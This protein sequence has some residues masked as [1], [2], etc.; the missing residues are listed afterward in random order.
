MN[1]WCS[2]YF[3]RVV[4]FETEVKRGASQ[5]EKD[6]LYEEI[7]VEAWENSREID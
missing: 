5:K 3:D 4:T 6:D 7:C 2:T 1:N